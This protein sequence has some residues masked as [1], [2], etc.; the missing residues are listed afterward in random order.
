MT[1]TEIKNSSHDCCSIS[2]TIWAKESLLNR[3]TEFLMNQG[4]QEQIVG[5]Q[6]L[7]FLFPYLLRPQSKGAELPMSQGAQ[8]RT[9]GQQ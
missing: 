7:Q 4:A 8:E 2:P 1:Q 5:H 3:G 9:V 6:Y